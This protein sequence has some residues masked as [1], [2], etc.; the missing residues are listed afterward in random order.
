MCLKLPD[1]YKRAQSPGNAYRRDRFKGFALFSE[2]PDLLEVSIPAGKG[3][4][5]R[6]S[7]QDKLIDSL[8]GQL[9]LGASRVVD[10]S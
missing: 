7:G 10:S 2:F 6:V 5:I 3:F 8:V 9:S 4:N 1:I